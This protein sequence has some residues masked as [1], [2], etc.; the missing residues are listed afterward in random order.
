METTRDGLRYLVHH[1]RKDRSNEGGGTFSPAE[2]WS[3]L[4]G[5]THVVLVDAEKNPLKT[6]EGADI[7][8]IAYCQPDENFS[9]PLGRAIALGRARRML[10]TGK[11][12]RRRWFEL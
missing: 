9:R 10:E 1:F 4:G 7:I 6:A 2:G 12:Q 8:G 3:R 5:E 11:P